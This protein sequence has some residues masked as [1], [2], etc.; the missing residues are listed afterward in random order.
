MEQ[1][2][3]DF[4]EK[5]K[6]RWEV[7]VMYDGVRTGTFALLLSKALEAEGICRKMFQKCI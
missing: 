2:F 7:R 6:G 3:G 4:K 1:H 5:G